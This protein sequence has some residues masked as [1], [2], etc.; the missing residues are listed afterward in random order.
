MC[1]LLGTERHVHSQE[2]LVET[3][4]MPVRFA[5][6]DV[7]SRGLTRVWRQV[8]KTGFVS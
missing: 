3:R 7:W 5:W 1:L 4:T 6:S 2:R 8:P